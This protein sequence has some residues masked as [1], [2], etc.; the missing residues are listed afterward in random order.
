MI[1]FSYDIFIDE[2]KGPTDRNS[3]AEIMIWIGYCA[4]NSPLA[5]HYGADGKALPWATNIQLGG[6]SWDVYLFQ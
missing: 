6:K 3:N 5:D 4:P 2:V 1:C